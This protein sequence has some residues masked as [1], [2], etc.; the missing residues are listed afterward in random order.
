MLCLETFLADSWSNSFLVGML[1][2][3]MYPILFI[4]MSA[5]LT[6]RK[7]S[8]NRSLY[9][10]RPTDYWFV[11]LRALAIVG[12]LTS[13]FLGWAARSEKINFDLENANLKNTLG[14]FTA[15][16]LFREWFHYWVHRLCHSKALYNRIHARH[17]AITHV[18]GGVCDEIYAVPI[19]TIANMSVI[20][21]PF[22]LLLETHAL[23]IPPYIVIFGLLF[24]ISHCGREATF[25][26]TLLYFGRVI[27]Y[28]NQYHDDHH[29]YRHGNYSDLIPAIDRMF[30]TELVINRR[31]SLPAMKRWKA[32]KAHVLLG[33]RRSSMLQKSTD[34]LRAS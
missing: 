2:P 10:D 20:L 5:L 23:V 28:N 21:M 11:V 14:S 22:M 3:S 17:H 4:P 1:S 27:L 24:S 26:V 25:G 33:K 29:T 30:G 15:C 16:C 18:G 7:R 13:I 12:V 31:R 6:R 8:I 32:V 34:R 19:E 9:V